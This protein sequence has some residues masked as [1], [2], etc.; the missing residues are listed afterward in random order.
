MLTKLTPH[1]KYI[2]FNRFVHAFRDVLYVLCR[3]YFH[4]SQFLFTI[5][6]QDYCT[7]RNLLLE[8]PYFLPYDCSP[9]LSVYKWKYFHHTI[10]VHPRMLSTALFTKKNIKCGPIT[11]FIYFFKKSFKSIHNVAIYYSSIQNWHYLNLSK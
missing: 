3:H 2:Y 5:G 6:T 8:H 11:V 9:F 7:S 4:A 10:L 1:K